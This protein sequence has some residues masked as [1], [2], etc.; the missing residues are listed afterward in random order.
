MS[1]SSCLDCKE[2]VSSYN[3]YCPKCQPKYRTNDPGYWKT[4]GYDD[5]Q[6]P[7][8]SEELE[9]DRSKEWDEIAMEDATREQR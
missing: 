5:F 9:R 4:H 6:E 3:K 2:M 7:R 8:R 1:Y